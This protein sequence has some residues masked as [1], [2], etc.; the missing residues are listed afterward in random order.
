MFWW[1]RE[2]DVGGGGGVVDVVEDGVVAVVARVKRSVH[3]Q[4]VAGTDTKRPGRDCIA[5]RCKIARTPR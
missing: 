5:R 4:A 3:I 1:R 2:I